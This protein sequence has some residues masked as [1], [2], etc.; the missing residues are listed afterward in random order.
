[1]QRELSSNVATSIACKV[2][3]KNVKNG[4]VNSWEALD[5]FNPTQF[6][7]HKGKCALTQLLSCN[8]FNNWASSR[9]N[10]RPSDVVF[11][12]FSKALDSVPNAV[13]DYV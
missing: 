4:I 9:N 2:G 6:G 13:S 12:D 7:F 11:L 3:E 1:L 5:V 10:S 8:Y